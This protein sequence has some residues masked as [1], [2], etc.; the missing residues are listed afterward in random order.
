[1]RYKYET[2]MH[3]SQGSACGRSTGAE[4]ARAYKEAGYTGVFVTDHF[5][6]GNCAVDRSLPWEEKV[7]LFCKGYEDAK[8]EGDKIGLDV[9]FGF[10][11]CFDAADFLVYNLDKEWLKAHP[12]IDKWEPRKAFRTMREDGGIIIHAHPFRERDYINHIHLFPR[13][14]DGVEIVNGGHFPDEIM[15]ER[16]RLYAGMYELPVTSGSD[17]HFAGHVPGCGVASDVRMEKITEYLELMK[18][19][20]LELLPV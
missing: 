4:M 2:H 11:Y 6:N 13:D 16:A 1:M 14:V 5:F 8:E 7:E 12:D 20:R 17:A 18:E 15:N 19:G 9:F 3:T 10:E